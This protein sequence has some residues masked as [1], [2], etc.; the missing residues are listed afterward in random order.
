MIGL[1]SAAFRL[2]VELQSAVQIAVVGQRQ[3]V[4]P[5]LLRTLETNLSI[6]PAPSSRLKWLWQCR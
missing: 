2:A 3:G 4:H 1:I 5:V 6:E